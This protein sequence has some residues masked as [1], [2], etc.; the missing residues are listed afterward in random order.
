[1]AHH[2]DAGPNS[3]DGPVVWVQER[4]NSKTGVSL[5]IGTV[6]DHPYLDPKPLSKF[7]NRSPTAL[8]LA[9]LVELRGE[10][11]PEVD[12]FKRASDASPADEDDVIDLNKYGLTMDDPIL[13]VNHH[14]DAQ[15]VYQMVGTL[16]GRD[17]DGNLTSGG[18]NKNKQGKSSGSKSTKSD[19]K[20]KK[21][22]RRRSSSTSSASSSASS[23]SSSS[24][25]SDSDRV[26]CRSDKSITTYCAPL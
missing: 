11:G 21:P 4:A 22:K 8:D 13:L 15:H 1:M 6:D 25:S 3:S 24:S 23:S 16:S 17:K 20:P 2:R 5:F 12:V 26:Y 19:R 14:H 9:N 7:E 10:G 18:K